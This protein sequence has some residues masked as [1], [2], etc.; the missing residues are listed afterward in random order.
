MADGILH[1]EDVEEG[2]SI[3]AVS[4]EITRN[5][6]VMRVS[7]TRDIFPLHHDPD[8][9]QAAGYKGPAVATAFLQGLLW[10]CLTDWTGPR[11]RI[12]TLALTL[13]AASCA[14]DTI[15]TSGKVARKYVKDGDHRVDCDLTVTRQ[16]GTVALNAEATVSVPLG[17]SRLRSDAPDKY[18]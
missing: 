8:F 2:S 9:A 14:G 7:A 10:R 12:R 16:D 4:M 6:I 1:W 11:G 17:S 5:R 18:E 15:T 13:K 3:P